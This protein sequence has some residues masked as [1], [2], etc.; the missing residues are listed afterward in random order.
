MCAP[1]RIVTVLGLLGTLCGVLCAE[2]EVSWEE[3]SSSETFSNRNE[4]EWVEAFEA[5]STP[6]IAELIKSIPTQG[7][8]DCKYLTKSPA[9]DYSS[10]SAPRSIA[11]R[12]GGAADPNTLIDTTTNTKF[13]N[14]DY[15]VNTVKFTAIDG[16]QTNVHYTMSKFPA[17]LDDKKCSGRPQMCVESTKDTGIYLDSCLSRFRYSYLSSQLYNA[18]SRYNNKKPETESFAQTVIEVL[19]AW[20]HKYPKY[21][22]RKVNSNDPVE[23][24]YCR[25]GGYCVL[26]SGWNGIAHEYD[27][28]AKLLRA[29]QKVQS[30]THWE[31]L[32]KKRGYDAREH[33]KKNIFGFEADVPI[34]GGETFFQSLIKGNLLGWTQYYTDFSIVLRDKK[35]TD[36]LVR[37]AM[38]VVGQAGRDGFCQVSLRT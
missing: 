7:P 37:F 35:Y 24:Q 33:I 22:Y 6:T 26:A 2:N 27:E 4:D 23:P 18:G 36:F 32:S 29:Y 13:P 19:D 25:D 17:A 3:S 28:A 21:T 1:G 9:V 34:I 31:V 12:W 8:V 30:S 16:S 11:W 5:G 14:K 38:G 15:K 20:A 10:G